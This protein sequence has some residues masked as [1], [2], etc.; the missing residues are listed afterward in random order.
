MIKLTLYVWRRPVG[1]PHC[2]AWLLTTVNKGQFERLVEGLFTGSNAI[3]AEACA[4]IKNKNN[5]RV[6]IN[7]SF[8]TLHV[9]LL[10]A[11]QLSVFCRHGV[12]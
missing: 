11:C 1:P 4:K 3:K 10:S 8:V 12:T 2:L 6:Y 5:L 9:Q 7:I